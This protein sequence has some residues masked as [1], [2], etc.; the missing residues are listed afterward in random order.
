LIMSELIGKSTA[1]SPDVG[2]N[3]PLPNLETPNGDSATAEA[4]SGEVKTVRVRLDGG[5][6]PNSPNMEMSG[7]PSARLDDGNV[8]EVGPYLIDGVLAHGGMGVIYR[9]IDTRLKR[10]VALKMII[11]GAHACPATL[12]RFRGEAEAV[13]RLQHTNIVQIYEVGEHQGLPFLALEYVEGRSLLQLI[14]D[15]SF[16][17]RQAAELVR[18]LA[19]AVDF[20]HQRGIIHRDIKPGNIL[21]TGPG[22]PKITDFGLAKLKGSQDTHTR[23]GEVIGTPN[24]MAPEQAEGDPRLVGPVADVY[25]LGAVLY[26]LLT[27]QPPFQGGSPM[28]TLMRVKLKDAVPPRHFQPKIPRDLETICLKCLEKERHRRYPSA[29]ELAEDLGHVLEG[30]TINARPVSIL[31]RTWKWSQR[32]PAVALLT[33]SMIACLVVSY[34]VILIQWRDAKAARAEVEERSLELTHLQQDLE[35]ERWA[36][37]VAQARAERAVVRGDW[38][39]YLA[40]LNQAEREYLT[41]DAG[42]ALELLEQ[43]KPELR[44]WEW[45]YLRR[46]V[47]GSAATIRLS[48]G[49]IVGA[50]YLPDNRILA[51]LTSAGRVV[52]RRGGSGEVTRDVVLKRGDSIPKDSFM[53]RGEFSADSKTVAAAFRFTAASERPSYGIGVWSAE[54]G[55]LSRF[56]KFSNGEPLRISFRADGRML[57]V[58]G[59]E[60]RARRGAD[61]WLGGGLEI[62]DL[63]SGAPL[64]DRKT[65]A[66]EPS[67]IDAS[68]VPG[69]NQLA[70][71]RRN[72]PLSFWDAATGKTVRDFPVKGTF[73]QG[74]CADPKGNIIAVRDGENVHLWD[75][76]GASLGKL[77]TRHDFVS[78]L[79]FSGN[80]RRLLTAGADRI[81]RVWDLSIH[82]PISTLVGHGAAIGLARLSD[83][84]QRVASFGTDGALKLWDAVRDGPPSFV[85]NSGREWTPGVAFGPEMKWLAA[86][87]GN[88]EILVWDM[89]SGLS[90][91]TINCPAGVACLTVSPDGS[92]IAVGYDGSRGAAFWDPLTGKPLGEIPIKAQINAVAFS[93]DG[94][95]LLTAG[96]Q[97]LATIWDAESRQ[98]ITHFTLHKGTV[99]AGAFT[100]NN[101]FAATADRDGVVHL[102]EPA[103]GKSI[104]TIHAHATRT[105]CV[106]FSPDG[107]MLATANQNRSRPDL[108]VQ[109]RIWDVYSGEMIREMS[110]HDL[111]IWCLAFT[112]DG[113]RLVSGS[114]DKTIKVW[115]PRRGQ[116]LLTLKGHSDDVRC[117]AFSFDGKVLASSNDDNFIRLWDATPINEGPGIQAR[118]LNRQ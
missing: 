24:Y 61:E 11:S 46:R 82:Q 92:K 18:T 118:F 17:P 99:L 27:G 95:R 65:P 59:G 90:L 103:T 93:P 98:A 53:S 102:W 60:L 45:N 32:H 115:E 81:L 105:T 20:A 110:G 70:L 78:Y 14:G 71:T 106:A 50:T 84:G 9:A 57:A 23:P 77:T 41:Q 96:D 26:E 54:T 101:R 91:G 15:K 63:E 30:R 38:A 28:E 74:V 42:K 33:F 12:A 117:L 5:N 73:G 94:R 108:P 22:V 37:R 10:P 3:P 97:G 56:W 111:S 112:P 100:R 4:S 1:P 113:E 25:S 69:T 47:E 107:S 35:R 88:G 85:T 29:A 68:F 83:D 55:N 2:Q 48:P 75:K 64:W 16:M 62:R 86:G 44:S 89:S 114:E 8:R 21:I 80:G 13:A 31:E 7:L 76:D 87:S 34:A 36:A 67:V 52:L 6:S 58:V 51:T 79:G 109:I 72:I 40:K 39:D 43:C 19:L 49:E 116:L 104:F 66:D